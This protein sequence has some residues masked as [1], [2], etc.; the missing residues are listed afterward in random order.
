M[1]HKNSNKNLKKSEYL[2]RRFGNSLIFI[3]FIRPLKKAIDFPANL[4]KSSE[5]P[6]I[7][8]KFYEFSYLRGFSQST[9]Q[10]FSQLSRG[11]WK[12]PEL[13][14]SQRTSQQHRKRK[15]FLNPRNFH[16]FY[17]V[18]IPSGNRS[19]STNFGHKQGNHSRGATR[20]P[21]FCLKLIKL[22]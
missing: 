17:E 20:I 8:H 9:S 21:K 11:S 5:V 18:C 10:N 15:L 14:R 7:F 16:K 4:A 19:C 2:L 3:S 1:Q 22:S 13:P 12:F 6:Q